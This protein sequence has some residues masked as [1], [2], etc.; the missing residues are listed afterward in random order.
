M[1]W[2]E[3][4]EPIPVTSISDLAEETISPSP[5]EKKWVFR[6][7]TENLPLT[8]SLER[9]CSSLHISQHGNE[10]EKILQREFQRRFYHYETHVP[11]PNDNLEW[12]ATMQHYGAATRLLDWTH[13]LYVALYFALERAAPE[14][15]KNSY[16][17]VWAV[18]LRWLQATAMD[19]IRRHP[20]Y[21]KMSAKQ[22]K[23]VRNFM[24]NSPT[25]DEKIIASN[26]LYQLNPPPKFVF[27][28]TPFN[29]NTR[30]TMQKGLFICPADPADTFVSNLEA[31]P[32]IKNGYGSSGSD[33]RKILKF[34]I[35]RES[36]RNLLKGL[37]SMNV[38][39]DSLFPGLDGFAR[40]LSVYHHRFD[41]LT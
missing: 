10:I 39:A 37:Q 1:N 19:L 34:Q 23:E 16:A 2:L 24:L 29:L 9:L 20:Q 26:W 31:M 41:E 25:A 8:T 12:L 18:D 14:T 38:S 32:G 40:S 6:G 27:P 35:C 30:L 21:V 4:I 13:S 15:P 11:A 22:K 28:A 36:R 17:V 7:Q 5:S 33:Q 3:K